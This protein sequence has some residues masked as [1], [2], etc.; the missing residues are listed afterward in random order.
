M[1]NKDR[2]YWTLQITGWTVYALLEIFT[3][4]LLSEDQSISTKRLLFL[5]FEAFSCL[6]LTH[7]FRTLIKSWNWMSKKLSWIIPRTLLAVL[8][9]SLLIYFMRV[10][11]SMLL[12]L[13]SPGVV[14]SAG[15]VAGL[16]TV[17]IVI[18]FVW[19]IMYFTY[20]YFDRYNNSLKMEASLREIELNNL[21]SQLNPHF[22]FN[23]LNSIRALV[24]ENPV[25]S[26]QAI[27]QLS[28][29][30]RSSLST[31]K[32]ELT[33]LS[34]EM[35]IVRDYLGLES[36][37][38]E[39]RLRSDLQIAPETLEWMV[40]PLMIQTLVENGIKH[41]ISKLTEGGLIQVKTFLE[42]GRLKIL[43]RNSGKFDPTLL[44]D[45]KGLGIDN[46]LKRLKLIYGNQAFFKINTQTDNTVLTELEIPL[47]R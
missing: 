42:N 1:V 16:S 20:N 4:V 29:L 47:I 31:G 40:P 41:G 3:A 39:E 32:R 35:K 28:S 17:Y 6:L 43:V 26:K 44:Q 5:T 46:T 34:E 18:F 22:I 9:M 37:R 30:L 12:G 25:K 38:F 45:G 7:I 33:S 8:V 11:A 27:T 10:P 14:F 36:I 21:K 24:D 23:A 15:N 19:A 13:F 2:L